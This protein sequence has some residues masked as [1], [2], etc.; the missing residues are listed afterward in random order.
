MVF[1]S[2]VKREYIA[3]GLRFALRSIRSL[4]SG[5]ENDSL[6]EGDISYTHNELRRVET[7]IR[8][9]RKTVENH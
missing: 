2:N 8:R 7:V 3:S 9:L 4:L 1:V 6:I 5:I